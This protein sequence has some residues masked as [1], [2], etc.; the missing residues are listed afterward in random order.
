ML[1]GLAEARS[2]YFYAK[3][4][5]KLVFWV[6][7][8]T[9]QI[10]NTE[11]LLSYLQAWPESQLIAEQSTVAFSVIYW[12]GNTGVEVAQFRAGLHKH[13]GGIELEQFTYASFLE[14]TK[15]KKHWR[16]ELYF[17]N[18]QELE[19]S[20]AKIQGLASLLPGLK[21]REKSQT[22]YLVYR[23]AHPLVH[24]ALNTQLKKLFV[25][26]FFENENIFDETAPLVVAD[27]ITYESFLG[28]IPGQDEC[29]LLKFENNYAIEEALK[30]IGKPGQHF[31]V[32]RFGIPFAYQMA[33][34]P[35]PD[36]LPFAIKV[37]NKIK[38]HFSTLQIEVI[39]LEELRLRR[40]IR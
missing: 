38:S 24:S 10:N 16:L 30:I 23:N 5:P 22:F 35:E 2:N 18:P 15:N 40:R 31:H 25:G 17:E 37:L 11:K 29:W 21:V 13:F 19:D 32:Y 26:K 14:I 7:F 3:L 20:R 28:P 9:I 39:T 1:G 4:N 8:P 6:Q 36:G 27:T 33:L 34:I 12:F